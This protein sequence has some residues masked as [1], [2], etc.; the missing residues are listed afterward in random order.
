M[1][2]GYKKNKAFDFIIVSATHTKLYVVAYVLFR[3]NRPSHVSDISVL[4]K[5]RQEIGNNRK[6]F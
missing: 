4:I 1:V 2:V 3:T 5:V 6:L